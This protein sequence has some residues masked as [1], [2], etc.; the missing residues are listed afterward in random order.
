MRRTGSGNG[1]R[2]GPP[3]RVTPSGAPPSDAAGPA[4]RAWPI[5]A[6]CRRHDTM[7]A[8]GRRS[9]TTPRLGAPRSLVPPNRV[10]AR[11]AP[12]APAHDA[13]S[14]SAPAAPGPHLAMPSI[15]PAPH[16][17]LTHARPRRPVA[18]P[19]TTGGPAPTAAGRRPGSHSPAH[20]TCATS[21]ALTTTARRPR[22]Q[23]TAY[24]SCALSILRRVVDRSTRRPPLDATRPRR[25]AARANAV[26]RPDAPMAGCDG[27]RPRS[28]AHS[29][30]PTPRASR[31]SCAAHP[32]APRTVRRA[33]QAWRHRHPVGSIA[34]RRPRRR[35]S[36]SLP[37]AGRARRRAP[38]GRAA[39]PPETDGAVMPPR[40]LVAGYRP[41]RPDRPA[42]AGGSTV[43]A[44][45]YAP[46]T[47]VRRPAQPCP[48]RAQYPPP[49]AG[50]A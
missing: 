9:R 41:P 16:A 39:A 8:P 7:P 31:P 11:K 33:P 46:K 19:R 36:G 14:C 28:P 15:A 47:L 43:P 22:R 24:P 42:A 30:A 23:G 40:M 44:E 4:G 25:P 10:T 45:G 17:P 34:T 35:L 18:R 2:P 1:R 37:R 26:R 27:P 6:L 13:T 29:P 21:R 3:P 20:R 50:A 5:G 49:C 32:A 38:I 12:A 48:C